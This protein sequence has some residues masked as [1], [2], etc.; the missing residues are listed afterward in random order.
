MPVSSDWDILRQFP[1]GPGG[2]EN[3]HLHAIPVRTLCCFLSRADQTLIS[4]EPRSSWRT[5]FRRWLQCS[6][7]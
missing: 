4:S 1:H 3:W 7:W 5:D 6:H 2:P